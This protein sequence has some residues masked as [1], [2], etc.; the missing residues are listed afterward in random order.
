MADILTAI[1]SH[2]GVTHLDFS[3]KMGK[4]YKHLIY[5][6]EMEMINICTKSC[7]ASL[8]SKDMQI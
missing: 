4:G 5:R 7:S 8:I 3:R 6:K 1:H 2:L